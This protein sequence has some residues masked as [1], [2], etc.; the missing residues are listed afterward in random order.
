MCQKFGP[1]S[2]RGK[3]SYTYASN[4]AQPSLIWTFGP[5]SIRPF[6]ASYSASPSRLHPWTMVLGLLPTGHQ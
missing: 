1:L 3:K 2:P 5:D 4:P 6:L